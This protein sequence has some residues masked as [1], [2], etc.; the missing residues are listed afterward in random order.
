MAV[1]ESASKQL[2][3]AFKYIPVLHG[4][5]IRQSV[6][7]FPAVPTSK[8]VTENCSCI[9]CISHIR[10]GHVYCYRKFPLPGEG[11]GHPLS[12]YRE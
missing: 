8:W 11:D 7:G 4:E 3:H 12:L 10:V 1:A 9:F 2:L 5:C 6:H